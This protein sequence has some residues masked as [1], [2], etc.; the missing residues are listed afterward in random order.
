MCGDMHGMVCD[1][2]PT[3]PLHVFL[4]LQT[5]E[6]ASPESLTKSLTNSDHPSTRPP[7]HQSRHPGTPPEKPIKP[8]D[9]L[10]LMV[11]AVACSV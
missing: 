8:G 4:D 7:A 6:T 3:H 1:A 2:T 5:K 9:S 10:V 11:K